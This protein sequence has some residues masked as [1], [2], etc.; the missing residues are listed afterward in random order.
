MRLLRELHFIGLSGFSISR[1]AIRKEKKKNQPRRYIIQYNTSLAEIAVI[2]TPLIPVLKIEV[3][4]SKIIS[5]LNKY[6]ITQSRGRLEMNQQH[7]LQER[8]WKEERRP[9][10]KLMQWV[11]DKKEKKMMKRHYKCWGKMV[12][13]QR[14]WIHQLGLFKMNNLTFWDDQYHFLSIGIYR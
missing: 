3:F 12:W 5:R 6:Y 10:T 13:Y 7:V 4:F 9:R 11:K 8:D 2:S 1:T 14:V